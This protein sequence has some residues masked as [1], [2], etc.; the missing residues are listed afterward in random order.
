MNIIL[1]PSDGHLPFLS[2]SFAAYSVE[3]CCRLELHTVCAMKMMV[4]LSVVCHTATKQIAKSFATI[5][6]WRTPWIE[7]PNAHLFH[8]RLCDGRNSFTVNVIHWWRRINKLFWNRQHDITYNLVSDD[9]YWMPQPQLTQKIPISI[10]SGVEM[11]FIPFS[12]QIKCHRK[13]T[14]PAII[15]R[16]KFGSTG[17]KINIK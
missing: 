15:C 17:K 3:H 9:A 10:R 16:Y 2:W 6:Y 7:W 8:C 14:G 11:S 4:R 13:F 12:R 5:A 1:W